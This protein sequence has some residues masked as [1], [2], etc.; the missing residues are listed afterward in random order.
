M[1]LARTELKCSCRR[2]RRGDVVVHF[3]AAIVVGAYQAP[4]PM[5]R[6][7]S[8][9]NILHAYIKKLDAVQF[10]RAQ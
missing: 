9:Q 10:E 6:W 8:E 1:K 3:G 2:I 7:A 5:S 4:N